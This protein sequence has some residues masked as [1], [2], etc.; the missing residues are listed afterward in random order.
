MTIWIYIEEKNS[1]IG[2]A[3]KDLSTYFAIH[4]TF[5]L[6]MSKSNAKDKK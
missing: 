6:S 3:N 2:R 4:N 1:F 5:I